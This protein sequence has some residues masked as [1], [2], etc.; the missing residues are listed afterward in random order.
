MQRAGARPLSGI[1]KVDVILTTYRRATFVAEAVESVLAQSLE[2][3]HMTVYD[4]G[5]G[6][7]EI[8]AAVEPFLGDD[9]IAYEP[10]G[11]VLAQADNWTRAIRRGSAPYVAMLHD[12]D[13]WH[14]DFLRARIDALEAHPECGFAYGES[15]IVDERG[16]EVGREPAR[17]PEGVLSRAVLAQLLTRECMIMPPAIVVRRAAYEAVG[18]AF[19]PDAHY[20]DWEMWARLGARFPAYYVARHDSDFRRH[21]TTLTVT[22]GP[23]PD[24]VLAMLAGIEREFEHEL[25]GEFRLGPI[26]RRRI[27]SY[28]LL[29]AASDVHVAG[30]WRV[31]GALYRRAVRTYPP[32]VFRYLS[33]RMVTRTVLGPRAS[34]FVARMLRPVRAWRDGRSRR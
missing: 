15:V 1:A 23:D 29:R 33:L 30:G 3:W 12:D 26:E 8:E 27:R 7:A 22:N 24:R 19:S 11:D 34:A 31:S 25:E 13:R 4:N 16:Q 20:G 14:P 18:A 32:T 17:Q 28:T 2:D 9:R 21:P 5:P 6:E 10:M